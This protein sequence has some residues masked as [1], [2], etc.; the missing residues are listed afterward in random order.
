MLLDEV[1]S[2]IVYF[3]LH[4]FYLNFQ[5]FPSYNSECC[6]VAISKYVVILYWIFMTMLFFLCQ[7]QFTCYY[8]QFKNVSSQTFKMLWR[9][10]STP[11]LLLLSGSSWL[12]VVVSGEYG[13]PLHCYYSHTHNWP[14]VLI[15]VM[16]PSISQI[17]WFK[18]YSYS[19]GPCAKTKT[20]NTKRYKLECIGL[21]SRVFTNGSGDQG[22]ITGWIIP[23]TQK[24]VLDAALH[25]TQYYKGKI[26]K[27]KMEQSKERSSVL[28]YTSV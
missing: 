23:K 2:T 11:S 13:V 27:G 3:Y 14:K 8:I 15:H 25:N 17:N 20:N 6:F 24:M 7:S 10:W 22:S 19:I 5:C 4:F 9:M 26:I 21:R 28:P 16:V 1:L 18:N 12:R